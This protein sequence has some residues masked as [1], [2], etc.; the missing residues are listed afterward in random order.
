MFTTLKNNLEIKNKKALSKK[1]LFLKGLNH[2]LSS[3]NGLGVGSKGKVYFW[4]KSENSF[5]TRIAVRPPG[6]WTEGKAWQSL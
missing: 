6:I 4:L 3:R 1:F 2:I 5:S